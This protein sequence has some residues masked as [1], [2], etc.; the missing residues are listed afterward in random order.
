M[1]DIAHGACRVIVDGIYNH[2]YYACHS[3]L[4]TSHYGAVVQ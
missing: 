1:G 2:T 4:P 3:A